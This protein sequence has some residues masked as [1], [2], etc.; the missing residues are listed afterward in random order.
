M[1]QFYAGGVTKIT[2]SVLELCTVETKPL[3]AVFLGA[4]QLKEKTSVRL[5]FLW[6]GGRVVTPS[7]PP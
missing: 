6:E 1:V 2:G 7:R 5:K 4:M 3:F